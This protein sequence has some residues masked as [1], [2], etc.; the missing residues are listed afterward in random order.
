MAASPPNTSSPP[1]D[2]SR[3]LKGLRAG[4]MVRP[5]PLVLVLSLVHGS[6]SSLRSWLIVT[7]RLGDR[8]GRSRDASGLRLA[9]TRRRLGARLEHERQMPGVAAG[10]LAVERQRPRALEHGRRSWRASDMPMPPNFSQ[11]YTCIYE[12]QRETSARG[13]SP[14]RRRTRGALGSPGRR[15]SSVLRHRHDRPRT[16][17]AEPGRLGFATKDLVGLGVFR[18]SS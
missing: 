5:L 9:I 3:S 12:L 13:T 2:D 7:S 14:S 18:L 15:W 4:A 11:G 1:M 8:G 17:G 6:A 10:A 16:A